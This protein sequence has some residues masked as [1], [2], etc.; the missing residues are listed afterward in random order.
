M[1]AVASCSVPSPPPTPQVAVANRTPSASAVPGPLES[2]PR[3]ELPSGPCGR[4]KIGRPAERVIRAGARL[5]PLIRPLSGAAAVPS[6]RVS[7]GGPA[8]NLDSRAAGGAP[9]DQCPYIVDEAGTV[10][11]E[12]VGNKVA[13]NIRLTQRCRVR[14]W[15]GPGITRPTSVETVHNSWMGE[16]QARCALGA[17]KRRRC[18]ATLTWSRAV[19]PPKGGMCGESPQRAREPSRP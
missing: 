4:G 11:P 6:L 14:L 17:L 2:T 9:L 19:S 13:R 18:G 15:F 10:G 7:R 3:L 12:V 8:A 16:P 5:S 1:S